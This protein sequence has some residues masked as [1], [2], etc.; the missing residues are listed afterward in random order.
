MFHLIEPRLGRIS[1]GLRYNHAVLDA[2]NGRITRHELA[3]TWPE[4]SDDDIDQL[5]QLLAR[6]DGPVLIDGLIGCALETPLKAH[7]PIV[8]LVHA[9][10][11]TPEAKRRQE[12]CLQAADAVV[13][14]SQ[15]AADTLQQ[16][17]GVEAVVAAPGVRSRPLAIGSNGTHFVSVGGL[18]PNKNQRFLATVLTELHA[19]GVSGW[20]CTFAGPT[21]DAAYAEALRQ[22]LAQ[23]PASNATIAGELDTAALDALYDSADLLLLPSRAETFGLVVQEATAAGLPAFVTAGTGAEEALGG[24]AALELDHTTWVEALQRWLADPVY[25]N[26]LQDDAKVARQQLT[27][28]WRATADT[29]LEVLESACLG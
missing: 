17:Y 20:H 10:A 16:R 15:Y 21:T 2:A 27:Y 6:L 7:V 1:G 26:R 8:Q 5:D 22:D 24:G 28:G 23:L 4:P 12:E 18:E 13:A 19:M 29:I 3:G 25:R 11:A 9:L 14:T